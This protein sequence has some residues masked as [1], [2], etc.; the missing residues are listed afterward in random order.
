MGTISAAGFLFYFA[1][2]LECFAWLSWWAAAISQS[3]SAVDSTSLQE[4]V[5]SLFV[6][7]QH[8]TVYPASFELWTTLNWFTYITGTWL[9][10]L[11]TH[12]PRSW[13][14]VQNWQSIGNLKFGN[15]LS[16]DT[17]EPEVYIYIGNHIPPPPFG[18]N[19]LPLYWNAFTRARVHMLRKAIMTF[20]S[21]YYHLT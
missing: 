11:K 9:L 17:R 5:Y 8:G 1:C 4:R 20:M 15:I 13:A 10:K 21:A 14:K 2:C 18:N 6:Y 16:E 7:Q 3:G 12:A 19:I